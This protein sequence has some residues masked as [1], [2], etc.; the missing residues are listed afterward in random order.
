[1]A[2]D[3]TEPGHTS[4]GLTFKPGTKNRVKLPEKIGS[5]MFTP[6]WNYDIPSGLVLSTFP[7]EDKSE[8]SKNL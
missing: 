6:E 7:P 5:H 2:S 1:M 4:V 3:R 8:R